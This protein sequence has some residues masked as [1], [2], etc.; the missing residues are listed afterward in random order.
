MLGTSHEIAKVLRESNLAD[1]IKTV[2]HG[3][4]RDVDRL[5]GAFLHSSRQEI[6]LVFDALF[7]TSKC[8]MS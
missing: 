8:C 6:S 5:T 1:D 2:E 7:I 4:L 3:P